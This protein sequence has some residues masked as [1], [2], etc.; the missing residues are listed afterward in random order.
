MRVSLACRLATRVH[1]ALRVG[2][3]STPSSSHPRRPKPA[4]VTTA[5]MSGGDAP[6]K[7]R[8]SYIDVGA[9][10][11]DGMFRGEYHGK[12]YHDPDLDVVLRRGWDAGV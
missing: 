8:R 9:N 4:R 12:T 2:L 5:T 7:R 1:T 3:A 10:L 11:T 6:T